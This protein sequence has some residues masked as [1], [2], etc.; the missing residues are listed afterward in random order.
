MPTISGLFT[1]PGDN[2]PLTGTWSA[3]IATA[4]ETG[5]VSDT[6]GSLRG[7]VETATD[8]GDGAT[9]TLP[10]GWY[11][12]TWESLVKV[13]GQRVQFGPVRFNLSNNTTWGVIRDAAP[14]LGPLQVTQFEQLSALLGAKV[15]VTDL[16][17]TVAIPRGI[18][19]FVDAVNGNDSNNGST[20]ATAFKTVAA[21]IAVIPAQGATITLSLDDHNFP[22]SVAW[23]RDRLGTIRGAAPV[24]A[25][26]QADG[27]FRQARLTSTATTKPSSF[28]NVP[29]GSSNA[30]GFNVESVYIDGDA[31][32]TNGAAFELHAVNRAVFS[33]IAGRTVSKI[34]DVLLVKSD[35]A[36]GDDGSW[37]TFRD[38]SLNGIALLDAANSNYLSVD[39]SNSIMG[40]T[41][42]TGRPTRPAIKVNV[43]SQPQLDVHI[44]GWVTGIQLTN[45]RGALCRPA[46]EW[47]NTLVELQSCYDS[48]VIANSS[49]GA[50][51]SEV[52]DNNGTN[53]TVIGA[54]HRKTSG[55]KQAVSIS[56]YGTTPTQ[57]S[58]G[59]ASPIFGAHPTRPNPGIEL[60]PDAMDV[61]SA[62]GITAE[63]WNGATW[64]AWTG[65]TQDVLAIAN[66]QA[67]TID[68]T[69]ARCRF[70]STG[71][72]NQ[73]QGL[74]YVRLQQF[75]GTDSTVTMRI[76]KSDSS[77]WQEYACTL[78]EIAQKR[79]ALASFY[80]GTVGDKFEVE[81]NLGLTGGQTAA[82]RRIALFAAD[83]HPNLRGKNLRASNP[84]EGSVPGFIGD[85][86]ECTDYR[87]AF[88]GWYVKTTDGG[89]T[90]WRRAALL[91]TSLPSLGA[92]ATDAATTQALANNI[93]TA[94]IN[95]GWATA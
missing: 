42:P 9:M 29:A 94:L 86:Y 72:F 66:D 93:R 30:Y 91:P 10:A 35:A 59:S 5:I 25:R 22:V 55:T 68:A 8:L 84:P 51:A 44:E 50:G 20:W 88:A 34:G 37:L 71:L 48:I 57:L 83:T 40:L 56:S 52:L 24:R 33:D 18:E 39:S 75:V 17:N 79:G 54:L 14:G 70:R 73:G 76:L 41:A 58:A 81:L 26:Q 87:A 92:A 19:L 67:V 6:D 49:A 11:D 36:G 45:V 16:V 15:N 12:F 27:S 3:R 89:N 38:T 85:T 28:I 74:G 65:I 90:G 4:D 80:E 2:S 62:G 7:G 63:Y 31:L 1:L 78:T 61:V 64:V 43:G 77:V 60:M 13:R 53:N 23:P 95:A 46:S 21:A 69:H 82:L 47:T 32:A